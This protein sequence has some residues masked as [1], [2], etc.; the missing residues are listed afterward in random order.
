MYFSGLGEVSE[1]NDGFSHPQDIQ[2]QMTHRHTRL[3][4]SFKVT[5]RRAGALLQPPNP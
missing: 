4:E 3:A 1:L 5:D 2:T